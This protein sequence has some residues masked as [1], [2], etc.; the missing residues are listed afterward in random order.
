MMKLSVNVIP[1]SLVLSLLPTPAVGQIVPDNSQGRE[2][3]QINQQ[4]TITGGAQRGKNLFHSFE[5]FNVGSDQA[6]IFANPANISNIFSRITGNSPSQINGTLSVQ[7][8]ANLFLLNPNGI[9]FGPEATLNLQGSFTAATANNIQFQNGTS[10]DTTAPNSPNL[11]VRVP[12]GLGFSSKTG[13]ITIRDQGHQTGS[14]PNFQTPTMEAAPPNQPPGLDIVPG[15]TIALFGNGISLEGALIR[16]PSG[17]VELGSINSGVV[18]LDLSKAVPQFQ[19]PGATNFTDI[20]MNNRSLL[21][22][23]GTPGGSITLQGQNLFQTG[24]S[25]I[26]ISNFGN[27]QSGSINITLTGSMQLNGVTTSAN[28][29][30]FASENR[31]A[32]PGI[33]TQSFAAGQ[34]GD[35]RFSVANNVHLE[36]FSTISAVTFSE[37]GSGNVIINSG[38][39]LTIIGT[40]PFPNQ[41]LPS[42]ISTRTVGKGNAG[43]VTLTGRTLNVEKGGTILS[44][45]QASGDTGNVVANFSNSVTSEGNFTVSSDLDRESVFASSIGANSTISG[46]ISEVHIQTEHLRLKNSGRINATTNGLGD[47]GNI[48]IDATNIT[49]DSP[50]N[51]NENGF[52]QAQITSAAEIASPA[53]MDIFDLPPRPQGNTGDITIVDN[54]TLTLSN[55]GFININN[56]G[57]GD[58]GN[59]VIDSNSISLANRGQITASTESGVGG[60]ININTN[61]L[62]GQGNSDILAN[63]QQGSGGEISITAN[64][65]FGFTPR[66][67]LQI[68]DTDRFQINEI[69]DIA[70]ISVRI[71]VWQNWGMREGQGSPVRGLCKACW[72]KVITERP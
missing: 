42:S 35:I 30:N 28:F 25:N 13:S 7:G 1:L 46:N 10:W 16:A 18:A 37:G 62:T 2:S 65:F 32:T 72:K 6:V 34:G 58:A 36:N 50:A 14:T 69:N 61:T 8:A 55:G 57:T 64:Q 31:I 49:V 40:P 45:S 33:W 15:Q 56:E 53:L 39:G 54:D 23:S 60:N 21:S 22:S 38:Q 47:G 20:Q 29:S 26:I 52:T 44:Q 9:I 68:L 11:T 27:A 19:Y 24:A 5:Q 71:Q 48:I 67:N 59:I 66:E 51:S 43:S 4:G 17:H 63:A 3:T 70:A 41:P 12:V